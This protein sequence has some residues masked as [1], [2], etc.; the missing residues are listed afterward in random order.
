MPLAGDKD[1]DYLGEPYEWGCYQD[2]VPYDKT[3]EY[4]TFI[5]V[6]DGKAESERHSLVFDNEHEYKKFKKLL[7]M[8]WEPNF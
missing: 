2:V 3:K 5:R 7:D 4:R 8:G 6:I 1:G